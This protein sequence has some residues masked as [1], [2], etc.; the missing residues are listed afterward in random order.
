MKLGGLDGCKKV[1]SWGSLDWPYEFG[2][3]FGFGVDGSAWNKSVRVSKGDVFGKVA[4]KPFVDNIH[5][6][7]YS[8]F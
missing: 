5:C 7:V 6:L 2:L 1:F 4:E 8:E 3:L